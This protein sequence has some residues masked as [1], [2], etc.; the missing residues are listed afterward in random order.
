MAWSLQV[1]FSLH[2]HIQHLTRDIVVVKFKVYHRDSPQDREGQTPSKSVSHH[3]QWWWNWNNGRPGVGQ[4]LQDACLQIPLRHSDLQPLFQICR[5]LWWVCCIW[6]FHTSQRG[7]STIIYGTTCVIKTH[8]QTEWRLSTN[9]IILHHFLNHCSLCLVKYTKH[10]H[11]TNKQTHTGSWISYSKMKSIL[12]TFEP[13]KSSSLMTS[14]ER[15]SCDLNS[16]V[17]SFNS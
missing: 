13:L 7:S 8:F 11:N 15:S 3:S 4:R 1:L 6:Q 12:V 2:S 10:T 17:S 5:T 16:T 9:C 14:G